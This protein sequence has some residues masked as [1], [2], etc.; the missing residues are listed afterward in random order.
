MTLE[1]YT[2][3]VNSYVASKTITGSG[4]K[5]INFNNLDYGTYVI[6]WHNNGSAQIN[7]SSANLSTS[8]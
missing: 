1:N 6:V 3:N 2:N 8:Y 5:T 7:I 4:S